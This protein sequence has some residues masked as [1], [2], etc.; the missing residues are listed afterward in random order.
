MIW[1]MIDLIYKY[2]QKLYQAGL[3]ASG[4]ALIGALDDTIIWNQ[5]HERLADFEYILMHLPVNAFIF[6]KPRMPYGFIIDYLSSNSRQAIYP[7]DTESRTFLH[8]LP[9]IHQWDR[10]KIIAALSHR[11]AVIISNM[12]VI[13]TGSMTPEQAFVVYSS[14]CFAC[15]VAF[16]FEK[17]QR[18][19]EK[20]LTNNDLDTIFSL[21]NDCAEMP[22]DFPNL[23]QGPFSTEDDIYSA[24]KEVGY[25][26]VYYGLVDSYF[27][28]VSYRHNDILYISQTASSLDELAGCIDPCPLDGSSCAAITAS[29][30]FSAHKQIVLSNQFKAILHGHPKFSVVMSMFCTERKNC[31]HRNRCHTHCLGDRKI[32]GIPII[33][34]EVGCGPYGLVHTLPKAFHDNK[35]VIVFGH[36]V[37]TVGEVDF[38]SAFQRL[39]LTEHICRETYLKWIQNNL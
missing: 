9:V 8:E 29:S 37:F 20:K 32:E 13:A 31:I 15:F 24:I 1:T 21:L 17:I 36:G 14:L 11:K 4:N 26:T 3:V 23:Q 27:G 25:D 39:A 35:R 28:N 12:G 16:F 38:I 30:E 33:P 22:S 6:A 10:E 2:E 34:G 18:A 5:H 19:Y 7:Q